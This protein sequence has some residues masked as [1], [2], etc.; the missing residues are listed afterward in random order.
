MNVHFHVRRFTSTQTS[1]GSN[2]P[3]CNPTVRESGMCVERLTTWKH[4]RRV[5]CRLYGTNRGR[6]T[7]LFSSDP[8]S[9]A[10]ERQQSFVVVNLKLAS[11]IAT[12]V[13][14]NNDDL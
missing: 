12:Q 10:E 13:L 7:R 3:D 5:R 9:S 14:G 4:V 8:F 11:L 6:C 2:R 1:D